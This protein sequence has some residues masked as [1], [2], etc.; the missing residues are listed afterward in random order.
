MPCARRSRGRDE[1]VGARS[2]VETDIWGRRGKRRGARSTRRTR[3]ERADGRGG[4]SA[5][6]GSTSAMVRDGPSA[7]GS[8]GTRV[9]CVARGEGRHIQGVFL[10]CHDMPHARPLDHHAI[11][12]RRTCGKRVAKLRILSKFETGLCEMTG[13]T[14]GR[15]LA[16]R[17]VAATCARRARWSASACW[18]RPRPS[19]RRR[20]RDLRSTRVV[21]P[22][23]LTARASRVPLPRSSDAPRSR[24]APSGAS[25]AAL[26]DGGR[27]E[28]RRG[29][30]TRG[31][32][33]TTRCLGG[34]GPRL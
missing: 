4:A 11:W 13:G 23:R 1:S 3:A 17:R 16:S 19:S 29:S 8:P 18:A 34:R 14:C 32:R 7:S 6:A 15:V 24:A 31:A 2:E 22:R 33:S 9:L 12:Y 20:R 27:D 5:A 26:G 25:V 10:F 30:P 21:R 28:S